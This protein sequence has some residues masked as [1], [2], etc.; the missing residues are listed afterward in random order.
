MNRFVDIKEISHRPI[1]NLDQTDKKILDILQSKFPLSTRPFRQIADKLVIEES[2]VI[3]RIHRL[4]RSGIIRR[5]GPVFDPKKLGYKSTLIAI[6]VPQESEETVV[7]F[8]NGFDNVTHNYKR[9]NPFNIW[10]T[11]A[12]KDVEKLENFIDTLRREYGVQKL[13]H[14]PSTKIYKLKTEF[15]PVI[16]DGDSKTIGCHPGLVCPER[17][18]RD[19]GFPVP[20]PSRGEGQDGG[21]GN[22]TIFD[23]PIESSPFESAASKTGLTEEG[24]I[25]E[26]M[27]AMDKGTV[28]RFGA[29]LNHTMVGYE[30]NV[31]LVWEI[32]DDLVDA[33]GT[34]IS[35]HPSVSH[36]YR[37][38]PAPDWPY[39]LYGML[40]AKN[41]AEGSG[42]ISTIRATVDA[43]SPKN[44]FLKLETLKEYKK[45]S[46][47]Y[48][49]FSAST[50]QP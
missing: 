42:L 16:P 20:S 41:K 36:C 46:F 15:I 40:H 7:S 27:Q 48:S 1:M 3:E 21:K 22:D 39:N 9:D 10:F 38:K 44:K 4:K 45:T 37:R 17:S 24:L 43:I 28:R 8:I 18:R 50:G 25:L 35:E 12:Y 19:P 11:F 33:A 23:L 31:M 13:L 26:I 34:A 32:P 49:R 14:V 29:V 6:S 47:D 30:Y 5:I 2:E